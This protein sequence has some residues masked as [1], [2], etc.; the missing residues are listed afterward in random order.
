MRNLVG[1]HPRLEL[2]CPEEEVER[3]QWDLSGVV[4]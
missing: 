2:G 3:A 4:T 1:K